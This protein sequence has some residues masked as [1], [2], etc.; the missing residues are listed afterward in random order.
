MDNTV[1]GINESG[2][3]ALSIEILDYRDKISELF[4]KINSCISKLPDNYQGEPCDEIMNKYN[5]LKNNFATVKDNIELYSD[6]IIFLIQKVKENDR[7][8]STL[9]Q[10]MTATTQAKTNI[11]ESNK[12]S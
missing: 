8:I 9:F 2:L 5:D 10:T 6:D 3:E 1:T 11:L 12:E 4:E 7:Y